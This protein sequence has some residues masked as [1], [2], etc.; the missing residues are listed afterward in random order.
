LTSATRWPLPPL[1]P[2]DWREL[3]LG[4]AG[5]LLA[6][7]SATEAA[8]GSEPSG[9]FVDY[10]RVRALR[11]KCAPRWRLVEAE[12]QFRDGAVG[13]LTV[14]FGPEGIVLPSVWASQPIAEHLWPD[15]GIPATDLEAAADFVRLVVNST[16][17]N[18]RRFALIEAPEHLIA[19]SEPD[20][21]PL[22]DVV[23]KIAPLN[24]TANDSGFT[25]TGTVLFEDTFN[26]ATF[27]LTADGYLQMVEDTPLAEIS[28]LAEAF[29]G[30][31][32]MRVMTCI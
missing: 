13:L 30:P 16:T 20:P 9:M 25:A 14:F 23:S 21:G 5:A 22:L 6:R 17:E 27:A 10:R 12:A 19:V 4:D 26:L 32:R 11:L 1:I 31:F 2:G 18:D 3:S 24:V 8:A 15:G 7:Y 28:P 29:R